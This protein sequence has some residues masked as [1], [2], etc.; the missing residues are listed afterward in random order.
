M[1]YIKRNIRKVLKAG[2]G[3]S[4]SLNLNFLTGELDSRL[5]VTRSGNTATRVNSS[6]LIEVVNANTARFDYNPTTLAL[7]GLLIEP[8]ATNLLLQSEN[9][10]TTW[11]NSFSTEVTNSV[12]SPDGTQ[13]ADSIV[14][15]GTAAAGHGMQ[16]SVSAASNTAYTLSQFLKAGTRTWAYLQL[17]DGAGVNRCTCFFNLATGAVGT[18][19]NNGTGSG[20]T[21]TI[22]D[23]GNGWYRCRL[24]GT[25]ASA[26]TGSVM[27][28]IRLST[29]DTTL[30][31]NGDNASLIYAWGAQLQAGTALTSYVPT[32]AS[33]VT[34]NADVI[35][36]T[37]SN[38][39]S[40]Y[41]AT[42]GTFLTEF[43]VRA[44]S[45]QTRPYYL[46]AADDGGANVNLIGSYIFNSSSQAD[47]IVT[48]ASASQ[49]AA[50]T[51][52]ITAGTRQKAA[53]AYQANNFA[54]S[55][56]GVAVTTD[57]SGTIPTVDRLTV[58]GRGDLLDARFF[59]GW[60]RLVRYF[61]I[62]LA[63]GTVQGQS[64]L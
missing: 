22:E 48:T 28:R 41:N 2:S 54:G 32:V 29:G 40:W 19:A 45:P 5:T 34:K 37:G 4:A 30:T 44:G 13:N 49:V 60:I 55:A 24:T 16:Q 35:Q 10:G 50:S 25:P 21:G 14:E 64:T 9:F 31:Y 56:N 26:S 52:A 8:A 57:T 63:D 58:G 53:I 46:V 51:G 27:S 47:Y 61:P 20:A 23:F 11:T 36:A 42:Q 43:E 3:A 15:D 59:N 17:D 6:G 1:L 7:R 39:T 12:T 62:R 18:A 38:F 33:S